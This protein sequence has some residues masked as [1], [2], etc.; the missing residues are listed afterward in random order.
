MPE[1][2]MAALVPVPSPLIDASGGQFLPAWR[3]RLQRNNADLRS[4]SRR[5]DWGQGQG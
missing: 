1:N 3:Q 5:G 4:A 2:G